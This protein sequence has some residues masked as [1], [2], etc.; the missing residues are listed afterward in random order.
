MNAMELMKILEDNCYVRTSGTEQELRCAQYIRDYVSGF[1]LEANLQP[2]D[3]SMHKI[4]KAE[5]TVDGI[6]IP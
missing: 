4:M 2:F 1:G 6:S 5:L 3:V